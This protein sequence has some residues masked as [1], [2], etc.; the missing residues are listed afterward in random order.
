[1]A[2]P[3]A[4][5]GLSGLPVVVSP[6]AHW[7]RR[8]VWLLLLMLSSAWLIVQLKGSIERLLEQKV[9]T[10]SRHEQKLNVPFPAVTI[11]SAQHFKR[12]QILNMT[13]DSTTMTQW[14]AI[15]GPERYKLLRWDEVNFDD[16]FDRAT[17]TYWDLVAECLFHGRPCDEIGTLTSIITSK[18][19]ACHTVAFSSPANGTWTT[20]QLELQLTMPER[21]GIESRGSGPGWYAMIHDASIVF[22]DT[23]LFSAFSFSPISLPPG[24]K[25]YVRMHRRYNTYISLKDDQCSD[26]FTVYEF[27]QC[28]KACIEDGL[29]EDGS[30][31]DKEGALSLDGGSGSKPDKE[32]VPRPSKILGKELDEEDAPPACRLPWE[33]STRDGSPCKSY[34]DLINA[35]HFTADLRMHDEAELYSIGSYDCGCVPPCTDVTYPMGTPDRT[36]LR[37]PNIARLELWL[38][39]RVETRTEEWSFTFDRFVAECGGNMGIFLGA[40]LLTLVEIFDVAV[41]WLLR[42]KDA[43]RV[44]M[45]EAFVRH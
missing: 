41:F 45:V 18:H 27:S 44:A 14:K 24:L 39:M 35:L 12:D 22:S 3:E 16:F 15:K 37:S 19:G 43:K 30:K 36:P 23:A 5:L 6:A 40:S 11:C 26:D 2:G 8:L 38:S 10:S 25:T 33:R 42:K 4:Q 7:L 21:E 31:R 17:Y 28:V 20:P 29:I 1:M 32:G 13:L 34:D 9:A